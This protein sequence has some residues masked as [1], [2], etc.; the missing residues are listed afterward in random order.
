[1]DRY[2]IPDEKRRRLESFIR[3]IDMVIYL[4]IVAGGV[5]ALFFTPTTVQVELAGWEWLIGVW[6]LLLLI[7]GGVGF[8]G[9]LTRY[10]VLEVPAAPAAVFGILIYL[11]ILGRTAFTS[12]TAAVATTLVFVA[13]LVMIR[14]YVELQIFASDPTHLD[15]QS[16]V[17]E[18]LRRRTQNVA[19]RTE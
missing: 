1:M 3:I 19:P 13:M 12:I 4:A 2:P 16:R 8:I 18:A 9:R 14:R 5:Y 7:G 11:V 10:W 6:S 15:F 17:A